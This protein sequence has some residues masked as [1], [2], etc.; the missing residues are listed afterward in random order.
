MSITRYIV[1][2][3]PDKKAKDKY[4]AAKILRDKLK[5]EGRISKWAYYNA[6][7]VYVDVNNT[8]TDGYFRL[9]VGRF[10]YVIALYGSDKPVLLE[11]DITIEGYF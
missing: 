9:Y 6:D 11:D 3:G 5:I 2:F 10:S 1:R 8:Y 7:C 4:K